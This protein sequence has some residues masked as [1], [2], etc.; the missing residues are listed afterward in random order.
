MRVIVAA[1][2]RPRNAAL[3]AAIQF[4]E[5]RAAR[6]WPLEVREIREEPARSATADQVRE[7]EGQRLAATVDAAALI[8]CD[9]RG[10]SMTSTTF[11]RFLQDA[12]ERARDLAFVIGGAYGL[13]PALRDGA[14][15]RLA[16]AT[17]TLPHEMARLVLAEQLY[18]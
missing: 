15:H 12:R 1:V 5:T 4:Y 11:A 2:G 9:E 6:Y 18:R 16:L 7:R 13:A 3:A 10:K 17:W 14:T 8:A